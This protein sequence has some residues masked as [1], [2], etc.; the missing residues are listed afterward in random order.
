MATLTKPEQTIYEGIKNNFSELHKFIVTRTYLH[1]LRT[2]E[3][4]LDALVKAAATKPIKTN[5]FPKMPDEIAMDYAVDLNEQLIIARIR[6]CQSA[7]AEG[8][9]PLQCD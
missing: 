7:D 2:I 8:R 3:P 1:T 6:F 4:R 9:R 5:K